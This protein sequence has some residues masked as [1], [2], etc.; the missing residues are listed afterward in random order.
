MINN[1]E[2]VSMFFANLHIFFGEMYL[3]LLKVF[4]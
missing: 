3:S 1:I 2:H 4:I